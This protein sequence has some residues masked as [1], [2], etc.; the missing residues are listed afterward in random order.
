ML[1]PPRIHLIAPAGSCRSFFE[2]LELR[3]AAEFIARVQGYLGTGFSVTA[4][5]GLLDA[6]ESEG[7]GGRDDD[8]RRA[9]DIQSALA[10]SEVAALILV[11]GG[12]W[13]AR[14]LPRI[15]F[16]VL[17]RR[18]TRV[19]V[20][21]FSE[22]TPLV[23]IVAACRHGVGMYDMGPA[24]LT[25]GLRRYAANHP[26]AIS[27][28]GMAPEGWVRAQL[29]PQLRDFFQDVARMITGQGSTRTLSAELVAGELPEHTT[30]VFVGGNLT[31]LST[32]VGSVYD[33]AVRPAG[34]WIMLEDYNDKLER[35][36]RFL[37]HLTLARYWDE[38]G[39][40][41][42]GDF[43][44]GERDWLDDVRAL[45]AFHLPANRPL[46]IL[47]A[48][49]L[50]HTWPMSP[51]PL[52]LPLTLERAEERSYTLHWPAEVLR[53]VSM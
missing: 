42:L 44:Q 26:H 51:L 24:F 13:F 38:A 21:G 32:M 46:P 25:Y 33:A 16:A 17:E 34:R 41:L 5:E 11:R 37:A 15:D 39:G 27:A 31:V 53:T 47:V 6:T 23:N 14:I 9:A 19:A 1:M 3:C 28:N 40:L 29:E 30:A 49:T 43:H 8:A 12:A 35:F 10:D 20:F 4:D 50:G 2:R 52:N 45:L 7:H 36:D 18:S 22:L 48:R